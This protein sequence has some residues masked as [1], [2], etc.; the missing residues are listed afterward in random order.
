MT[1]LTVRT[2]NHSTK[3]ISTILGVR[4]I[5]CGK[6]H[7]FSKSRSAPS[8]WLKCVPTMVFP[9]FICTFP[10][11]KLNEIRRSTLLSAITASP[12]RIIARLTAQRGRRILISRDARYAQLLGT[13]TARA[14][15]PQPTIAVSTVAATITRR[16]LPVLTGKKKSMIKGKLAVS[17]R[18]LPRE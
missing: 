11:F 17:P 10:N 12:L 3:F 8:R 16:L 5:T 7:V 6:T 4:Y 1:F 2:M 13:I 9:C 18:L 14:M 15:H